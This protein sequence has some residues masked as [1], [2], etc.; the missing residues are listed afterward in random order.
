M[1][2]FSKAIIILLIAGFTLFGWSIDSFATGFGNVYPSTPDSFATSFYAG[3]DRYTRAMPDSF[4]IFYTTTL[5]I[6]SLLDTT[7]NAVIYDSTGAVV[8]H[9]Y[10]GNRTPRFLA[11]FTGGI[12]QVLSNTL[13]FRILAD[14][15]SPPAPFASG[16]YL[17]KSWGKYYSSGSVFSDTAQRTFIVGVRASLLDTLF[18]IPDSTLLKNN[19]FKRNPLRVTAYPLYKKV[20]SKKP[21]LH[22]SFGRPPWP[23]QSGT[24]PWSGWSEGYY[25][26][27]LYQS[28][29]T[30]TLFV[31]NALGVPQDTVEIYNSGLGSP[32]HPGFVVAD[33]QFWGVDSEK[34]NFIWYKFPV[35]DSLNVD[36]SWDIGSSAYD[37]LP[38]GLQK[39]KF[40]ALW[41]FAKGIQVEASKMDSFKV[42]SDTTGVL[43]LTEPYPFSSSYSNGRP[44]IKTMFS[45]F[46][47]DTT[48]IIKG[49]KAETTLT[50]VYYNTTS[51]LDT[52]LVVAF[53][54]RNDTLFDKGILPPGIVSKTDT[55]GSGRIR[56]TLGWDEPERHIDTSTYGTPPQTHID[57]TYTYVYPEL[58][59]DSAYW[60]VVKGGIF[61][62][63]DL[64]VSSDTTATSSFMVDSVTPRMALEGLNQ[65]SVG[66]VSTSPSF[67][68][69]GDDP[70]SGVLT[71]SL[72]IDLYKADHGGIFVV[73]DTIETRSYLKNLTPS[74]FTLLAGV[75]LVH[76]GVELKDGELLDAWAFNGRPYA[77]GRYMNDFFE[78]YPDSLGPMDKV[79]NLTVPT[80]K[81]F[82]VDGMPPH[83]RISSN[84][85][86]QI[87]IFEISDT[88]SA[89]RLEAINDTT[90][91]TTVLCSGVN[92]GAVKLYEN[93]QLTSPDSTKYNSSTGIYTVC[94]SPNSEN[95]WLTLEAADKVGNKTTFR[96]YYEDDQ[97]SMDSP[98]NYPN[99]FSPIS[100][101]PGLR[102]TTIVPG[103]TK[104]TGVE[105]SIDIYDLAGHYVAS[106]EPDMSNRG[107]GVW[108]GRTKNGTLV[109]N[110]VYLCY[111]QV[112]DTAN[113]KTL[114]EVI[115]IAVAKNDE[116]KF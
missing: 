52:G 84:S 30:C 106:V 47:V 97:L 111:I 112:R 29:T 11:G 5:A 35:V 38:E 32:V 89:L 12:S 98:H 66:Y 90:I 70:K 13:T 116:R 33:S 9:I 67:I 56:F 74:D 6:D 103:L 88:S 82:Y 86:H 75:A 63:H 60:Y 77:V 83:V 113:G 64:L 51:L 76:T 24:F 107:R 71:D 44:E 4:K 101:I 55:L 62:Y 108:D 91:D 105:M 15:V 40:S 21:D 1:T 109:A 27:T 69:T 20:T 72:F 92:T 110:G 85:T 7:F 80:H 45:L 59:A 114:D 8:Y 48:I 115:K 42:R 96:N 53:Y 18:T 43:V 94:Y 57:T 58:G 3:V 65:D 61:D 87:L 54:P 25:F 95:V 73:G 17:L 41:N 2:S 26:D 79:W 68:L 23:T 22:A 19:L 28:G 102:T 100:Y 36:V 46:R 49:T 16:K 10:D 39:V 34:I 104:T 31:Y 14:S 99:P 37:T 50:T 81:R 78:T 93:F